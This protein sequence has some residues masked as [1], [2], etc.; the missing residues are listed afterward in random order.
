MYY[1]LNLFHGPES[2]K[3]EHETDHTAIG[4]PSFSV[5]MLLVVL[6]LLSFL[7]LICEAASEYRY[8][9]CSNETTFKPN[10]NYQSNLNHLLSSL[11]SNATRESGYYNA[12]AGQSPDTTVYGLFL[13][14]GDVSTDSCQTCVATATKEIVEQYCPVGKVAVIWYEECM[15]RYSNQ[16]FFS[17]M[18]EA[19]SISLYNIQNIAEPDRFTEVQAVPPPPTPVLLA[20]PPAPAPGKRR[21]SLLIIVA[22]VASILVALLLLAISYYFLSRRA[23]KKCNAVPDENGK[24]LN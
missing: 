12:T 1:K 3:Y 13:C 8:H 4:M 6:S 16:S 17:T 18:D 2:G 14:R 7:S 20:P 9:F 5:S 15:L 24:S 19:P 22:I 11:T 23:R 21:F 10:S